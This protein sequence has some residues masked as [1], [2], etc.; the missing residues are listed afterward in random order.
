MKPFAWQVTMNWT[1]FSP[2]ALEYFHESATPNDYFIGGL[3]GPGY[4]YPNHIPPEIFPKLMAQARDK[5]SK[6]RNLTISELHQEI[7]NKTIGSTSYQGN[8][9]DNILTQSKQQSMHYS[10]DLALQ[11]SLA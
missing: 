5:P 3:S 10:F 7:R 1:D 9:E 8:I 11:F 2:A 4:M 6:I